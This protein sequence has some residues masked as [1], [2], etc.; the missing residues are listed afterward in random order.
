MIKIIIT[1]SWDFKDYDFLEKKVSEILE[2][3]I[4]THD[5]EIISGRRRGVD[6][7]G[8]RFAKKHKHPL[9]IITAN[10]SVNGKSAGSQRDT[11]MAEY[12]D[13]LII[14]LD[15]LSKETKNMIEAMRKLDKPIFIILFKN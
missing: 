9:R 7:L 4:N 12:A 13:V 1:G 2:T 15:G 5:I 11:R 8:E 14:L 10:W 6:R 3:E